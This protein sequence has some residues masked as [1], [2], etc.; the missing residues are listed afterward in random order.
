MALAGNIGAGSGRSGFGKRVELSSLYALRYRQSL[1]RQLTTLIADVGDLL[2][3]RQFLGRNQPLR[4]SPS[5]PNA[6]V[7]LTSGR[8][9]IEAGA[10]IT[11]G[12]HDPLVKHACPL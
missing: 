3:R 12:V 10:F 6:A 8:S 9:G 11:L 5:M 4:P 2:N 1:P 7:L